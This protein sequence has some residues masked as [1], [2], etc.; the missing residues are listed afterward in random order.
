M[1]AEEIVE[2]HDSVTDTETF[3]LRSDGDDLA[4][5]LMAERY[6]TT[7]RRVEAIYEVKLGPADTGCPDTDLRLVPLGLL[8]VDVF[9]PE[10]FEGVVET[11]GTHGLAVGERVAV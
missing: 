11:G 10:R 8:R 5:H 6:R 2:D 3:Y 7:S 1:S 9:H 4:S